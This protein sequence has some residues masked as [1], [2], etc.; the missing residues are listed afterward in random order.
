MDTDRHSS[1]VVEV[2]TCR[3]TSRPIGKIAK[4]AQRISYWGRAGRTPTFRSKGRFGEMSHPI[5]LQNLS[6]AADA[7]VKSTT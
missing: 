5:L 4:V 7:D 1:L 6:E 3:S 2:G